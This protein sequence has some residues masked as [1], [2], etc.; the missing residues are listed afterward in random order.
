MIRKL[1]VI[2]NCTENCKMPYVMSLF[3]QM[4][5]PSEKSYLNYIEDIGA[6]FSRLRK[7][8]GG[9]FHHGDSFLRG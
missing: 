4:L 8:T 1:R 9:E 3:G 6:Q 2:K 5:E 7:G